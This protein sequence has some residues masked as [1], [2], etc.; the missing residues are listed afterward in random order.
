MTTTIRNK[1]SEILRCLRPS[2]EAR[3]PLLSRPSWINSPQSLFQAAR[4]M[5]LSGLWRTRFITVAS[6]VLEFGWVVVVYLM[7][8]VII[9]GLSRALAPV[10][11]EFFSSIFG[12]VLTFCFMAA[13]YLCFA[14]VDGVYQRHIKSK[15]DFINVH[16][17]LGFPIPLVMLNQSD[18]LSGRDIACVIGNF[19]ITNLASWAMVFAL[20][21]L[22]MSCVARMTGLVSDDFCL[23]QPIT[24]TLPRIETSWLSDSTLDQ[25]QQ[26]MFGRR[27][28][29]ANP[30]RAGPDEATSATPSQRSSV[31]SKD[32][33]PV[34]QVWHFWMSNFP[35]IASSLAVF[36][37]GAPVAAATNDDRILD[38]CVL[39][40]VW[41]LTLRLQRAFKASQ[42]C[43]DMPKLKNTIVTLMNPVLFTTL[44]MAAYTRA[45]AGAYGYGSIDKVLR[46]FSGGTPLYVLWTSVATGTPLS[47]G[48]S[49]WFGAGDAALSILECGILIW[50][51][52]LYECQRQL[53]SLAGFLTIILATAAAAGNVFL[54]VLGGKLVGLNAPAAQAF[55]ARSTTLAL[56]KPAMEALGGNLGVNAALVVSNG[57]LGQLCYPF[58]LD[59]LGVRR[60]DRVSRSSVNISDSGGRTSRLSLKP[61]LRTAQKDLPSGD[62]PFTISAG[63]TVGINGAA[64][65]VS[66]LYETR[67]RAAPYAALAMTVSGVMTVVF[68]T[69]EPFKGAVLGLAN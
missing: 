35:L 59:K 48:R 47:D 28:K 55:A 67:S 64:M 54:S 24:G 32:P 4:D 14:D 56:A 43:P 29:V 8:E 25:G 58:V 1:V 65:G 17:G 5:S 39:W 27:E 61:L 63:I 31:V 62:D 16:L 20:S 66:Y 68:T 38:G 21:L 7:S 45:K 22:V 33:V 6:N 50:G 11:L 46:D 49:P 69:V 34:S 12:M 30:P 57:I 23:P 18:I 9:W 37:I 3:N 60:E 19:V 53:F 15:V 10:H 26:R 40:F 44:L 51:F 36:L 52:K 42:L 41:V 13:A 2:N